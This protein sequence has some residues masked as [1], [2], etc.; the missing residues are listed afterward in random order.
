MTAISTSADL[1]ASNT[2]TEWVTIPVT[3][4]LRNFRDANR[5]FAVQISGVYSGTLTMQARDL[6]TGAVSNV[7]IF[8]PNTTLVKNGESPWPREYRIGFDVGAY[9]SGTAGITITSNGVA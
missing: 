8:D 4:G 7:E 1:S 5:G 2:W 6:N 3:D 9:T